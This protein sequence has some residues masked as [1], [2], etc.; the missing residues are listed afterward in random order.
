[1]GG[2]PRWVSGANVVAL[3]LGL[4]FFAPSPG[5]A[6]HAPPPE[7]LCVCARLSATAPKLTWSDPSGLSQGYVL[8]RSLVADF[9][10]DAIELAIARNTFDFADE[11]RSF[12]ARFY[13]RVASVAGGD[14]S[15]WSSVVVAR[16]G[17]GTAPRAPA[18]PDDVTVTPE[19][20][21][22]RIGWLN[23][24][25][26]ETGIWV[27]RSGDGGTTWAFRATLSLN[28]TTYLDAD[29]PTA[30]PTYRVWTFNAGGVSSSHEVTYANAS[31]VSP[32]VPS[33]GAIQP[34]LPTI[35]LPSGLVPSTL[36]T[37]GLIPSTLPTYGIIPPTRGLIPSTLPTQGLIPPT[38]GLI[39]PTRGLIP[40]VDPSQLMSQVPAPRDPSR[41]RFWAGLRT[42]GI[43]IF[44]V[45]VLPVN[46][47]GFNC[48]P[49]D[50]DRFM[51]CTPLVFPPNYEFCIY[52]DTSP[53]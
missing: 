6:A 22:L 16:N 26:N 18:A 12:G 35:G 53:V 46:C 32:T 52:N 8:Q 15:P 43:V 11:T 34:S 24:A 44:G 19:E 23:Q 2:I 39:P 45:W 30:G 29:P 40:G 28:S 4:V 31:R 20:G 41:L 1:M 21:G 51:T 50:R 48:A 47:L 7:N 37:Q 25:I 49:P 14:R 17:R 9:S 36:P 13:Y 27:E 38:Q 10:S 5:T 42:Q 33:I 3:V